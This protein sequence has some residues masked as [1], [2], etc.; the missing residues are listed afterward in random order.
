MPKRQPKSAKPSIKPHASLEEL[1]AA[2]KHCKACDLW[3]HATQ[4]VFSEGFPTAK[5]ILVGEQP[6]NQEDLEGGFS[7][8]SN[9]GRG[10]FKSFF[11]FSLSSA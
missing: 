7:G 11:S 10:R 4:T 1:K 2:A 6:G 5:I 8:G 9:S 3:K